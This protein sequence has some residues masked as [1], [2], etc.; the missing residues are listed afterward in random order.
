MCSGGFGGPLRLAWKVTF[1]RNPCER[2]RL[3]TMHSWMI[4]S[5]PASWRFVKFGLVCPWR[6]KRTN[7]LGKI[8]TAYWYLHGC[9]KCFLGSRLLFYVFSL[10]K[11]DLCHVGF[12]WGSLLLGD[13]PPLT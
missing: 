10:F 6:E 3:L 2:K 13:S 1:L 7:S 4:S 8:V 11:G 9:F 5:L 12:G